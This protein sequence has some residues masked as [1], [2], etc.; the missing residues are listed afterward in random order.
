MGKLSNAFVAKDIL[1]TKCWWEHQS[2][3]HILLYKF[4]KLCVKSNEK[5]RCSPGINGCSVLGDSSSWQ[6][7]KKRFLKY[8]KGQIAYQLLNT[9]GYHYFSST[10]LVLKFVVAV[11]SFQAKSIVF[12]RFVQLIYRIGW[13]NLAKLTTYLPSKPLTHE[14]INSQHPNGFY[15][16][17][18]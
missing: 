18:W 13:Q 16:L 4:L 15:C 3:I 8:K 17:S 1:M 11:M 2:L 7:S 12:T 10:V 9:T 14:N 6:R 5:K